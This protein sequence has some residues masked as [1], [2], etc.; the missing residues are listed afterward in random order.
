MHGE[1][2]SGVAGSLQSLA[3]FRHL[4]LLRLSI[5]TMPAWEKLGEIEVGVGL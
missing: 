3:L 5:I 1:L 4:L 2:A